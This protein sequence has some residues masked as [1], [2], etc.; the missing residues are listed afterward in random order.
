VVKLSDK[1]F[2]CAGEPS[3]LDAGQGYTAYL[4]QDGSTGRYLTATNE[5]VYRV[6]VTD[7]LG[8]MASDSV[9]LKVCD[10]LMVVPDAFTPNGDGL[11]DEFKVVTSQEGITGFSMR[12]FNRWGELVFESSDVHHGWN[13]MIKGNYAA[14]DTYAWKIVYQISSQTNSSS[15]TLHGTVI[16]I[17]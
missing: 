2:L 16:L 13:G 15:T 3:Q 5:G 10:A 12:I 8:C 14:P 7:S 6:T 4:W 11:N 17:R 1:A 9:L